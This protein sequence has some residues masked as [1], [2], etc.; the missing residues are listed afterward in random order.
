MQQLL[1]AMRVLNVSGLVCWVRCSILAFSVPAVAALQSNRALGWLDAV[2]AT[3]YLL[4]CLGEAGQFLLVSGADLAVSFLARPWLMLKCLPSRQRSTD[5]E[6]RAR[7]WDRML[8]G[9]SKLACG[10]G[11]GT[12]TTSAKFLGPG[13]LRVC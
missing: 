11:H 10:R 5:G 7:I 6:R 8:L 13:H 1:A 2:A 3:L 9:S 4:L 12:P